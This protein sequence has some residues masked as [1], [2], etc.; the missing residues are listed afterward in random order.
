VRIYR[1]S[2]IAAATLALCTFLPAT[3]VDAHTR[4]PGSCYRYLAEERAFATMTNHA[5]VAGSAAKLRLDPQ[6]SWVARTHTKAMARKASLFHAPGPQIT[7]RVTKWISLGENIGVG[8]AGD[9]AGLQKA[10]MHSPL[11]KA[12]LMNPDYRYVGIGVVVKDDTLWV[13]LDFESEAN[14]GTTLRLPSC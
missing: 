3:S 8:P 10:F 7:H 1:S 13:T 14:P 9:V 5:R 2:I 4:A 6:L 12:N 11:H